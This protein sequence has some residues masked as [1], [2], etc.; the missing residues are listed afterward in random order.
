VLTVPTDSW[1]STAQALLYLP[2]NY[3]NA[4]GRFPLIIHL[5]GIG[6][7]SSDINAMLTDGLCK[8]IA[9]GLK[10]KA[11]NPVDGK[12]YRFI[13]FSPQGPANSWGWP[14]SQI[15]QYM[16]PYLLKNY[17]IDS[18]RIY[19]TG[20]SAGGWGV[21]TFMD[22]DTNTVKNCSYKSY[23]ACKYRQHCPNKI[24]GK[25]WFAYMEYRGQRR[26]I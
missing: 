7:Q 17:K 18:T 9:D 6:Q 19:V 3:S 12:T 14:Q 16:L 4:K 24:C 1:G 5:P 23:C 20:Y 26:R 8:E 21:T 22:Q 10:P 15:M 25:I 2:V 13:V 11:V